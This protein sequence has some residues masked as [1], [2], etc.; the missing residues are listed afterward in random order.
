LAY[1]GRSFSTKDRDNDAHTGNC[2][3]DR[4]AAWWFRN[5]DYANLNGLYNDNTGNTVESG[6]NTVTLTITITM[7]H[8]KL[9]IAQSESHKK[10]TGSNSPLNEN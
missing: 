5:C 10:K 6:L 1:N 7:I 9:T 2:A 3:K 8:R 4:H